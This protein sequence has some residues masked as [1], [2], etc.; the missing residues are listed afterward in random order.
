MAAAAAAVAA[1]V[2]AVAAVVSQR[3]LLLRLGKTRTRG[4][5]GRFLPS[6]KV[7]TTSF[8]AGTGCRLQMG[9]TSKRTASCPIGST[10]HPVQSVT[11]YDKPPSLND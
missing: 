11:L 5:W 2:A 8:L 3:K 9:L 4:F 1:T 6:C 10:A 7:G